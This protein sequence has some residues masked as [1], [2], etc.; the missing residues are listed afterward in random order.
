M[1]A[2][3]PQPAMAAGGHRFKF[4]M[5]THAQP[6]DT[7]WD[8]IRKGAE[9]A[10]KKDDA[11]LIYVN[12]PSADG[13]ARLITNMINQ[14]VDGIAVTL[15]FPEAEAA[16]IKQA[17]QAG[18]PIVGF[19]AGTGVWKK[20]G[21]TS[22]VG[23]DET[24]AGKAVGNRLNAE[25]AKDI[26]CVDQQQGAIQLEQRCDGIKDTFKGKVSILYLH[27][28]D[29]GVAHARML[30][31]LQQDP[32]IDYIVTLGAPFAPTAYQAVQD[33]SSKANVGTFDMSPTV[34]KLIQEGK[35][36]WAVDQQPYVEGYLAI[37]FLW[38]YQTNGDVVG[39]GQAVLTGPTFV[40]HKNIAQVAKY[41]ARGTR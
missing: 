2:L 33:A 31:K 17:Q 6:G 23:Q 27:G 7:F 40:D 26:I 1:V 14:H 35:V 29:M 37:D 39:G 3:S 4:A 21:I 16:T 11:Q 13:E 41:A 19:N 32:K 36:Q 25:G 20:L 34:V 5:V 10:A 38:L 18:I 8:I 24:I 15:A 28:Y 12:N 30:A 9:A 22:Y